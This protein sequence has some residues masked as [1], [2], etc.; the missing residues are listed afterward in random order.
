MLPLLRLKRH[1]RASYDYHWHDAGL[2]RKRLRHGGVMVV[3][4]NLLL[5]LLL[6]RRVAARAAAATRAATARLHTIRHAASDAETALTRADS[7]AAVAGEE[8]TEQV[9]DTAHQREENFR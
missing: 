5:R 3:M 8:A 4:D 7:N 6:L 9:T 1:G 2:D